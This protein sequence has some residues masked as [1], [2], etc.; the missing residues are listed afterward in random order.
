[1]LIGANEQT[2]D[3]WEYTY[4]KPISVVISCALDTWGAMSDIRHGLSLTTSV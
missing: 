4:M 1:M 2:T 3:I